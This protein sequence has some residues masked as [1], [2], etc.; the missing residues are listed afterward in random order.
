MPK[1]LITRAAAY[2]V[3]ALVV[4]S[5]ICLFAFSIIKARGPFDAPIMSKGEMKI[6]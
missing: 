6:H 5:L 4:S 2:A 1:D 3:I